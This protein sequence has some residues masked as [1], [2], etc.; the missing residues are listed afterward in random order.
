MPRVVPFND[1]T[2]FLAHLQLLPSPRASTV[3]WPPLLAW[4]LSRLCL[5]LGSLFLT[6]DESL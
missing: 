4:Q 1:Q 3:P 5:T 6:L 2:L